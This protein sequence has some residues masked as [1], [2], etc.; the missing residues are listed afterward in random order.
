MYLFDKKLKKYFLN[1][2][3]QSIM[4]TLTLIIILY[5]ENMFTNAAIVASMGATTFI[6][7]AML[8]YTTIQPRRI[9]GGYVMGIIVGIFCSYTGSH[10]QNTNIFFIS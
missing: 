9:I 1:Y 6:I 10:V 4:A 8:K 5:F 2:L 7:F 3:F